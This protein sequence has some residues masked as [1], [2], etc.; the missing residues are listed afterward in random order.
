MKIIRKKKKKKKGKIGKNDDNKFYSYSNGKN[1][2]FGKMKFMRNLKIFKEKNG[3]NL[4]HIPVVFYLKTFRIITNGKNRIKEYPNEYDNLIS[5]S[6][7][8]FN[9][10]P[11]L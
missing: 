6:F 8:E 2:V 7:L 4:I 10:F 9:P 1:I 3:P 5:K 11:I